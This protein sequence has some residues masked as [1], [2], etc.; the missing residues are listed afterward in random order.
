MSVPAAV[1]M[2]A[3]VAA[4]AVLQQHVQHN[5]VVLMVL[6]PVALQVTVALAAALAARLAAL[7]GH[8]PSQPK[9]LHLFFFLVFSL[10]MKTL[11]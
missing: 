6:Q 8:T 9:H 4:M 1:P 7:A 11:S 2:V 3:A 5:H 10:K